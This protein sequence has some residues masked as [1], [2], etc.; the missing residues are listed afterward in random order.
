MLVQSQRAT[1]RSF[2]CVRFGNVIGSRGSVVPIFQKQIVRGEAVTLTHPDAERY[3]MTIPEAVRLLI[4]AGTLGSG[5][6]VFVLDMGRPV[7]IANLAR[8]LIELSGL[9][10]E[11]DIPIRVTELQKGEK[12]SEELLDPD[13]EELLSTRFNKVRVVRGQPVDFAGLAAKLATLE[14]AASKGNSQGTLRI[15]RDFGIGF[16][17]APMRVP[18]KVETA[19]APAEQEDAVATLQLSLPSLATA[20]P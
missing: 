14:E 2:C 10:P 4:Q 12:L 3:L 13:C 7:R 8:H 9:R 20:R 18:S 19:V 16:G 6:E 17:P 15:L 11:F 1:G 5:G